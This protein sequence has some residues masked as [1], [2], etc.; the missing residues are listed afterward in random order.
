MNKIVEN[1]R[2][3]WSEDVTSLLNRL[4]SI[5]NI[6]DDP[7]YFDNWST[8]DFIERIKEH[9]FFNDVDWKKLSNKEVPAIINITEIV[10]KIQN[11][12]AHGFKLVNKR[13]FKNYGYG[14]NEFEK[15]EMKLVEKHDLNSAPSDMF[16]SAHCSQNDKQYYKDVQHICKPRVTGWQTPKVKEKSHATTMGKCFYLVVL[17]VCC[18]LY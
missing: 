12:S 15:Q 5:P 11:H 2:C 18:K 1:L 10:R 6:Y 9:K 14:W 7:D 17:I 13:K 3:K 8:I 4:A 16:P